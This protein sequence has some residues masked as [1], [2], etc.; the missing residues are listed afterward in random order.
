MFDA[1]PARRFPAWPGK[2]NYDGWYWSRT[3]GKHIPFESLFE[4]EAMIVSDYDQTVI[5]IAAQP[6]A[7]LWPRSASHHFPDLALLRDDGAVEL[8]DVRPDATA[9]ITK[10]RHSSA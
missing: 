10:P 8:V 5:D 2:R 6:F 9:S 3:T 1:R 4:R 7:L